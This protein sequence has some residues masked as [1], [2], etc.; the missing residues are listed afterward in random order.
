[1]VHALSVR[2]LRPAT[3][4]A[5]ERARG[6]EEPVPALRDSHQLE[7]SI[8]DRRVSIPWEGR[9]PRGL[10]RGAVVAKLKAQAEKKVDR[11][12]DALQLDFYERLTK[13]PRSEIG[14]PTLLPLPWEE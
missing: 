12:R 1:M 3:R 14:A 13:G 8:G 11:I 9:N 4:A 6:P 2:E 7:L 5:L 10:T